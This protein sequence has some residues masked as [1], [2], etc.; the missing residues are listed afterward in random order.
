MKKFSYTSLLTLIGIPILITT[1]CTKSSS[2]G[3]DP[4]PNPPTTLRVTLTPFESFDEFH[5][6]WSITGE[7]IESGAVTQVTGS[8][9]IQRNI[10]GAGLDEQTVLLTSGGEEIE[11]LFKVVGRVS[12]K[13][14]L[15][16]NTLWYDT[17]DRVSR[18]FLGSYLLINGKSLIQTYDNFAE[19]NSLE[20]V[21]LRLVDDNTFIK[22]LDRRNNLDDDWESVRELTFTRD[23]TA[24]STPA[25]TSKCT[26]SRYRSLDYLLAN[27]GPSDIENRAFIQ[28]RYFLYHLERTNT[29]GTIEFS[30]ILSGCGLRVTSIGMAAEFYE[31]VVLPGRLLHKDVTLAHTNNEVYDI[32][33][34]DELNQWELF[35]QSFTGGEYLE[36]VDPR[37]IFMNQ[38]PFS[39][40]IGGGQSDSGIKRW[41]QYTDPTFR[42]A[43]VF[44]STYAAGKREILPVTY[45]DI[46]SNID[47]VTFVDV[48]NPGVGL[49]G[50]PMNRRSLRVFHRNSTPE[51][52]KVSFIGFDTQIGSIYDPETKTFV[53]GEGAYAIAKKTLMQ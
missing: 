13:D 28:S 31:S 29:E 1:A 8:S 24:S 3:P 9:I 47:R 25:N 16:L 44:E 37:A 49:N 50:S 30:S 2:T 39:P 40:I 46:N 18:K 6:K 20:R 51:F 22:T 38:N 43:S 4:D 21:V 10:I 27:A 7:I 11:D 34:N 12:R 42:I 36:S 52:G 45:T 32:L 33:F 26:D 14:S 48:E 17:R 15:Q 5:G 35:S 23:E 53:E 19:S 41:E